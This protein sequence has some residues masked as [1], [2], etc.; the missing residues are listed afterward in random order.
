MFPVSWKSKSI[1]FVDITYFVS[2]CYDLGNILW[3]QLAMEKS[4]ELYVTIITSKSRS[5]TALEEFS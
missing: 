1:Y 3:S 2:N 5:S 4:N